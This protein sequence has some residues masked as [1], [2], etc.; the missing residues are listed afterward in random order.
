MKF[1]CGN[2]SARKR[3]AEGGYKRCIKGAYAYVHRL[4][5]ALDALER[6]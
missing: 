6:I 2:E 3:V 1:Y 5:T 4:S